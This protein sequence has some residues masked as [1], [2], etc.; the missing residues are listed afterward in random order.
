MEKLGRGFFIIILSH[1]AVGLLSLL[2][3]IPFPILTKV[4]AWLGGIYYPVDGKRKKIGLDN[5]RLALGEDHSD[6]E[7]KTILKSVYRNM[8]SALMEF[9]AIPRMSKEAIRKRI[10]MVGRE[11]LEASKQEGRGVVLLTAHIGN[12]ELNAQCVAAYGFPLYGIGREANVKRLHDY[13]VRS[14]ESHGNRVFVRDNAMRKI[15]KVLKKGEI[16]GILVDQRGS[17]SRGLMIDFFGHPAPTDPVLA[18]MILRSGAVVMTCFGVRNPDNHHTFTISDPIQINLT[19]DSDKDATEMTQAYL[20]AIEH[21]IKEH[22]DQWLWMHRR[23]MRRNS[24]I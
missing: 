17:T 2:S 10:R 13:I 22:P 24:S 1:V 19:G 8:G 5:L 18:K 23:W 6:Q 7:L 9:A 14:R 3:F 15:L 20:S 21:Y 11:K 12:W 4:G 16:V